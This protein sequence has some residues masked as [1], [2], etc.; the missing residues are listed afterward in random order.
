MGIQPSDGIDIIV[1]N[2]KSSPSLGIVVVSSHPVIQLPGHPGC[3][4]CRVY[5]TLT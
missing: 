4:E 3:W 5:I 1:R 2:N